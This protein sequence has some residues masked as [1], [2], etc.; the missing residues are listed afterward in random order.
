MPLLREVAE[1]EGGGTN[2]GAVRA[3]SEGLDAA[4]ACHD[5]PQ[6][7][8]MTASPATR[9]RQYDR[10]LSRRTASKPSTYGPF[11]VR[12]YARSDW[13]ELDWCTR[14]PKA[15]SDNAAAAPAT[16]WPATTRACRPSS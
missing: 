11:A 14:W 2:A 8:D 5:Y 15:A 1:A 12:E 3:Y 16:R 7:Y 13:Q 10:A 4:V 6:L 9:L